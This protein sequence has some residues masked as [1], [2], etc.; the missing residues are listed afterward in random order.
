MAKLQ[1]VRIDRQMT[2]K[3]LAE[4]ANISF[5]MLQSYEQGA[6]QIDNA[7]FETLLK[8]CLALGCKLEEV[9][10]REDLL[11]LVKEYEDRG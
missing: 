9:L 11:Q 10:E 2:Q 1:D 5:R 8:I 6:K 4:Q 7:R 3:Q